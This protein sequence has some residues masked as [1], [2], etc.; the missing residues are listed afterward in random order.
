MSID[1]HTQLKNLRLYGIADTWA[2]IQAEA[3]QRQQALS[4]ELL[5]SQLVNAEVTDRY[6]R[7]LRYQLKVAKFPIHRDLTALMGCLQAMIV[8]SDQTSSSASVRVIGSAF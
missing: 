1:L 8:N 3:P 5:L 4:P 2:E 7:S 6:A